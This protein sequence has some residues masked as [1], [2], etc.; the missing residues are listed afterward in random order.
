MSE[1]YSLPLLRSDHRDTDSHDRSGRTAATMDRM[2]EDKPTPPVPDLEQL[3]KEVEFTAYQASG[4]GGQHRNRTYSAIRARH[5]PTGI[6]VTAADSRSQLRNRKIA[7][8]RLHE[9]L[10]EHFHVDPPRKPTRKGKAVR[11]RE[12]REREHLSEKKQERKKPDL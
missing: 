4:P 11:R 9:R 6:V 2:A 1:W 3:E 5:L 10:V 8:E 7:L 12:R